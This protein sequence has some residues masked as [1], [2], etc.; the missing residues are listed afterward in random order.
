MFEFLNAHRADLQYIAS[1]GLGLAMLRWGGGPERAVAAIF[2]GVIMGPLIAF[3]LWA[4]TGSMMFGELAPI[5]VALDVT[6]LVG[7]VLIG[8]NANRNYP[9]WIAGFQI[10]AVGAHLVQGL[11]GSVSPVA[12][13]LLAVGPSYC[14]LVLMLV[15]LLRHRARIRRFG[16]YR[17]WRRDHGLPKLA[18]ALSGRSVM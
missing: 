6:A 12:Y 17:D 4:T 14:Q 1:L 2:T 10:V 15:G 5:Y 18:A 9:L 3:R 8:L 13:V 7:F 16:A 11:I